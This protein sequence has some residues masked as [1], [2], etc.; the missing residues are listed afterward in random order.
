[1]MNVPSPVC[2]S[3]DMARVEIKTAR[4]NS[5]APRTAS[6]NMPHTFSQVRT[7]QGWQHLPSNKQNRY[8]Y[9]SHLALPLALLKRFRMPLESFCMPDKITIAI[10]HLKNTPGVHAFYLRSLSITGIKIKGN[11]A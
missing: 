4:V 7:C 3:P 5:A 9:M 11:Y 8:L 6:A 10:C 2:T 1:M